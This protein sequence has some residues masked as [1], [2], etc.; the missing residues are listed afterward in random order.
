MSTNRNSGALVGLVH[1]QE[2]DARA[3]REQTG[4]VSSHFIFR[5]LHV[6]HALERPA[7]T[8]MSLLER[9]DWS[10]HVSRRVWPSG[11]HQLGVSECTPYWSLRQLE[12]VTP[13]GASCKCLRG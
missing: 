3:H 8:I 13:S 2:T 9:L 1:L 10:L 5:L 4:L 11:E 7:L 12:A 6:K